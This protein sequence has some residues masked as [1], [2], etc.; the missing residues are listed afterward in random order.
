MGFLSIQSITPPGVVLP[1]AGSSPPE[2]WLLCQGQPLNTTTYAALFAAIGY[3]YGGFG[4]NFN[5][6][7]TR[8]IFLRGIGTQTIGS[9]SYS[10]TLG[11]KQNDQMQGHN[12]E[13]VIQSL[14]DTGGGDARGSDDY[15]LRAARTSVPLNDGTNGDPRYGTETRPA[16]IGINYI[17]KF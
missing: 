2:G 10:T 13:Y 16:N 7:D 5:L 11:S 14:E 4:A 6:P 8:G 12:H 3:T 9:I 1:F 17:I 15:P